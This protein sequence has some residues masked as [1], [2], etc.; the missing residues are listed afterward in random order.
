MAGFE[1]LEIGG[2]RYPD[3]ACAGNSLGNLS[4]AQPPDSEVGARQHPGRGRP[5]RDRVPIPWLASDEASFTITANFTVDG[6][7][8]VR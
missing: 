8:P 7:R 3:G 1:V 5:P 6:R 4:G 2:E